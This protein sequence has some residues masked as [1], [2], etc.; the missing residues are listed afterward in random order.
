[1][2]L[3]EIIQEIPRLSL[4]ERRILTNKLL[5]L[6]PGREDIEMCNE[7]AD[8]TLQILDRLEEEDTRRNKGE[9]RY[10]T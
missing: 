7:V 6:E 3:T 4:P 8:Q 9:V 10:R 5:E 2:S 1:M